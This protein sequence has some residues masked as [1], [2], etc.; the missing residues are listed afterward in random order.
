VNTHSHWKALL[1]LLFSSAAVNKAHNSEVF[2]QKSLGVSCHV[3]PKCIII[4]TNAQADVCLRESTN[5]RGATDYLSARCHC[6]AAQTRQMSMFSLSAYLPVR[7]SSVRSR[8]S[9]TVFLSSPNFL[10]LLPVATA[11]SLSNDN[12]KHFR[13]SGL[14]QLTVMP[15]TCQEAVVPCGWEDNRRPGV[16]LAMP[17][18]LQWFIHVRDQGPRKGDEHPAYTPHGV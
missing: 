7:L 6:S 4:N 16:A 2:L 5:P 15:G 8:I 14:C 1:E 11:R 18:R 13:F 10:G 17:H 12:D 3:I 9:E